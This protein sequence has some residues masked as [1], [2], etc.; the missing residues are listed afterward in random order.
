MLLVIN[1]KKSTL[2]RCTEHSTK[3]FISYQYI[4]RHTSFCCYLTIQK[5]WL[6][7][8]P[9]STQLT[10]QCNKLCKSFS[11]CWITHLCNRY[12]LQSGIWIFTVSS[13]R[14]FTRLY[15]MAVS[16]NV[17]NLHSRHTSFQSWCLRI[18]RWEKCTSVFDLNNDNICTWDDWTGIDYVNLPAGSSSSL[19]LISWS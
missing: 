16:R 3:T 17:N 1:N 13:T 2:N 8:W 12:F 15:I 14:N 7:R 5:L 9:H 18:F 6:T 19:L 4:H 11:I 10:N